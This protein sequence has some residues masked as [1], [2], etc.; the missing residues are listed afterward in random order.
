VRRGIEPK[1]KRRAENQRGVFAN[2]RLFVG[3]RA[4]LL[5]KA[6]HMHRDHQDEGNDGR[7]NA[8][9]QQQGLEKNAVGRDP[10]DFYRGG[11]SGAAALFG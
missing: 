8:H 11:G 2:G 1:Q 5:K 9:C 7:W 4:S 3:P 6:S 10:L